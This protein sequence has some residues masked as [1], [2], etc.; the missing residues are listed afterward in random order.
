MRPEQ[1]NWI[2]IG[3]M[4]TGKSTVAE[5]LARKTGRKLVDLDAEIVNEA[6]CPI[7]DIFEQQG[8][9]AF[10]ALE[11]SV[12]DRILQNQQ[13]VLATGGG[14]V[15]KPENCSLMRDKGWV[16]ALKADAAAILKRVGEDSGRPL[17]A[18]GAQER[19]IR[20]L[21]ERKH[22]YDFAHC[23]VD[24]NGLEPEQVAEQI[25]MHQRV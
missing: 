21:E 25:L 20:L 7:A 4:G 23:T 1:E 16:I 12:L 6:G 24:T 9:A 8:E 5:L 13:V 3:M 22:A 14:A 10:R 17:L 11:S 2:L 18:G 19:I 15:L